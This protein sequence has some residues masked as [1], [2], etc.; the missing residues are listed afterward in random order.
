[1]KGLVCPHLWIKGSFNE[2]VI[3]QLLLL[4]DKG[5]NK[6][7]IPCFCDSKLL[8]WMGPERENNRL[9]LSDMTAKN[10]NSFPKSFSLS[11]IHFA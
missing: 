1:M 10:Q 3:R 5:K 11:A 8:F 6:S 2:G 7:L 4:A 9:V